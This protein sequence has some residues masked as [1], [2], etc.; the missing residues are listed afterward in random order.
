MDKTDHWS[1]GSQVNVKSPNS[2][3]AESIAKRYRS[4]RSEIV[5]NSGGHCIECAAVTAN[6]FRRKCHRRCGIA[7]IPS[8]GVFTISGV[9]GELIPHARLSRHLK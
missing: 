6:G 8:R 7:P 3:M 1:G 5:R 4:K 9:F 2:G